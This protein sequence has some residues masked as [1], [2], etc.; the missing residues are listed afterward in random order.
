[1][2]VALNHKNIRQDPQRTSNIEAFIS[3]RTETLEND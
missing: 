2:P 1:M 3:C